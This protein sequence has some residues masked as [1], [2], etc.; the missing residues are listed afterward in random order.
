MLQNLVISLV[1]HERVITTSP[2]AKEARSLAEK[3]IT[4]GKEG[5]LHA[6]RLAIKKLNNKIA[7]NKIF[8]DLAKR[9]AD[10]KGGYTRILKLENT[11]LGDNASQVVFEWVEKAS[12]TEAE[13]PVAEEK[14]EA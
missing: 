14:T 9:N 6:R 10:R 8:S 1:E 11:R 7:V 5:T 4:L 13:A 2:R 12:A 3:V